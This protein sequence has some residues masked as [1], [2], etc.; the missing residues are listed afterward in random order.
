MIPSACVSTTALDEAAPP[1]AD[2]FWRSPPSCAKKMP[3]SERC[4]AV[5]EIVALIATVVNC[6]KM[7]C[8]VPW[9]VMLDA[10]TSLAVQFRSLPKRSAGVSSDGNVPT[11]T[12]LDVNALTVTLVNAVKFAGSVVKAG[13]G[14]R[15]GGTMAQLPFLAPETG[16]TSTVT[17]QLF[18]PAGTC[19]LATE[20]V[21]AL[22]TAV[23]ATTAF[24]HVPPLAGT[25]AT[26][27]LDGSVSVKLTLLAGGSPAWVVS[28]NT[29]VV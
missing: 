21:V 2:V 9:T 19:R 23:V 3:I 1:V 8:V 29:S 18:A 5:T 16:A 26:S 11:V 10:L 27:K 12:Q 20:I 22:A 4:V 7:H 6:P 24:A 15:A 14:V 28:V 25:G 13:G 17:V